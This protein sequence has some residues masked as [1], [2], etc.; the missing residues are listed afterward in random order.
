MNGS[1]EGWRFAVPV[2]LAVLA[3]TCV[4][5]L[6]GAATAPAG[7]VFAWGVGFLP[8]TLGN[9]VFTRQAAAGAWLLV[10]PYT[11]EPHPALFI[12]PLFILLGRLQGWTGWPPGLMF[13]AGRLVA[14]AALLH[15]IWRAAIR[16]CPG[17]GGQRTALLL[18]VTGGG[19]GFLAP[20]AP[21]FMGSADIGGAE[22]TT[23]FSLYQQVHFTAALALIV[24]LG[25]WLTEAVE[26]GSVRAAAW[27]GLC[28]LALDAVHPY[29]APVPVAAAL[30]FVLL[31]ALTVR[32]RPPV[33]WRAL[34]IFLAFPAPLMAWNG[35]LAAFVPVYRDYA[36][37]GLVA[38]PWPLASYL[39]GFALLVPLALAG[40]RG[41]WRTRTTAVSF[42]L[43]WLLAVPVLMALPIPAR[44]K[45]MEGFHLMLCF[46]AACG[47]SVLAPR[48]P[49]LR[50]AA[51]AAGLALLS[52]SGMYVM[53]RDMFAIRFARRPERAQVRLEAGALVVPSTSRADAWFSGSPWLAGILL[54]R[55]D[56]YDL[57]VDLLATFRWAATNLDRNMVLL[58][59]PETGLLVPMFTPH[60]VVAGHLFGT[61]RA[62]EKELAIRAVLDPSLPDPARRWL[63]G[64]LGAGVIVWDDRLAA[65]GGWRPEGVR[66]LSTLHRE[67]G[68]TLLGIAPAEDPA[69]VLLPRLQGETGASMLA[70]AGRDLFDQGRWQEAAGL[71]RRALALRPTDRRVRAW[72]ADAER[73]GS[74]RPP[75]PETRPPG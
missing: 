43:A 29:D 55:V 21:F 68:V 35:W 1:R 45:L 41:A 72:M 27:A 49:R 61:L 16:W 62:A 22:M 53:A 7:T 20:V 54:R 37:E 23:F 39:M 32:P 34:G 57:P 75:R 19:L 13:Q 59:A 63:V 70:L 60:R 10:N 40:L 48:G 74:G 36:R 69:P 38:A 12:H 65:R 2:G 50:R 30:V 73:A 14:G 58:A 4:P 42:P 31:R 64:Q 46:L 8:D 56:R 15:A 6:W 25:S 47:W 24:W 9:L 3:A 11:A 51:A 28:H 44:R 18:T 71:L 26:T 52:L 17:P 5:C 33:P 67:G 66:W